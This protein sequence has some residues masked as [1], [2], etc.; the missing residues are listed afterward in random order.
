MEN[1]QDSPVSI[2]LFGQLAVTAPDGTDLL[3]KS[4]KA[5]GLI[6]LLASARDY[7]RSRSWI[8]DRLWSDRG[9]DQAAGSLRQSLHEIRLALGVWAD[10]LV[11]DR[12]TVWLDGDRIVVPEPGE[13]PPSKIEFLQGLD[14]KDR[15]FDAWLGEMRAHFTAPRTASSAPRTLV[16]PAKKILSGLGGAPDRPERLTVALMGAGEGGAEEKL[17][18]TLFI[19]VAGHS[20]REV[21]DVEIVSGL[22]RLWAG[23]I[24]P[25]GTLIVIARAY[26]A[27]PD[28]Y[29]LR[30]S[31]EETGSLRSFWVDRLDVAKPLAAIADNVPCLALAHRLTRAVSEVLATGQLS[32]QRDRDSEG[33]ALWL[34]ASAFRKMFTMRHSELG[35]AEKLLS[36]AIALSPRGLFFAWRA[37]LAAIQFIELQAGDREGLREASQQDS[38]YALESEPLNS[39]VLAA[40]A[41]AQLVLENDVEQSGFL[42]RQA[43]AANRANPLAWWAWANATLYGGEPEAAYAAAITAQHLAERSTLKFWADF[44]RC[45]T[46]AITGR[47]EEAIRFGSM[48]STLAPS[49]RPPLR[50]LLALHAQSN[51][52]EAARR[53]AAR[54]GAIEADFSAER[55]L[56]DPSYPASLMRRANLITPELIKPLRG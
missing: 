11:S 55:L 29:G 42:A 20:L 3:P 33:E 49:F 27:A 46:A 7:R 2:S 44:Q 12:S 17:L 23:A 19:D 35:E 5:R 26:V 4:A 10:I 9:A 39:N 28:R 15:A 36:R 30:V 45:L 53:A 47:T 54:L 56:N 31:L 16:R 38:A 48:A 24:P 22:S 40:V 51:D 8:K 1:P 50:Y 14:V 37:Q 6:G 32:R 43:V 18:E 52:F 13:G 41:N 21:F 34:G 25:P